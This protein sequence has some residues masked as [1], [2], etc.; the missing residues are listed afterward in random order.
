MIIITYIVH[1]HL[2]VHNIIIYMSCFNCLQVSIDCTLLSRDRERDSTEALMK[3][4]TLCS[5]KKSLGKMEK[6]MSGTI[7]H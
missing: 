2:F 4:S 7:L 6:H 3:I 1:V 5:E